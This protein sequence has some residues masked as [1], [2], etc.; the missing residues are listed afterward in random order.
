[1]PPEGAIEGKRRRSRLTAIR[2]M[3]VITGP[4]SPGDAAQAK[5]HCAI[6][7]ETAINVPEG[8][9]ISGIRASA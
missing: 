3:P 9:R 6:A 2:Q 7:T 5:R 4:L 8:K 1:L